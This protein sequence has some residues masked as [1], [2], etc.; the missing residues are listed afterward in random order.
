[1][2]IATGAFAH[3]VRRTL[4]LGSGALVGAQLGARWSTRVRGRWIIRSLALG[5]GFVGIRILVMA[6]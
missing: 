4:W 1:V 2:H 5:L 3:G 6:L